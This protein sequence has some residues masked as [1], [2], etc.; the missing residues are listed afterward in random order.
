MV[1]GFLSQS[2]TSNVHFKLF[3]GGSRIHYCRH[4]D[5]N[6]YGC[7]V[8]A[9]LRVLAWVSL[10]IIVVLTLVP[11]AIR[12]VTSLPHIT[13]HA[14]IFLL[15][16][17]LFVLAY[18]IRISLFFIAAIVFSTCLELLQSYVPG[19]H[20]RL[21]DALIDAISACIGI[22]IAWVALRLLHHRN[23]LTRVRA[24]D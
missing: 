12:P 8:V 1:I 22:A 14:A 7:S 9:F 11:P 10:T 4:L 18:E 19:R 20:A 23:N 6:K 24:P 13:E 17:A 5:R 3:S 21:S 2:P 16:G 15:T